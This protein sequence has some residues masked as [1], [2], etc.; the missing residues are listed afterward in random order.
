MSSELELPRVIH[1][2][3][4]RIKIVATDLREATAIKMN[5][6][7]HK[8]E[9]RGKIFEMVHPDFMEINVCL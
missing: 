8:Q 3:N 7:K 2:S 6:L 4:I 1:T 9:I 5:N